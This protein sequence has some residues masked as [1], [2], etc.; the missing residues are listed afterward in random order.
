MLLDGFALQKQM[1]NGV[2]K[3]VHANP[4]VSTCLFFTIIL[5]SNNNERLKHREEDEHRS[6]PDPNI[7]RLQERH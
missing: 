5:E 7:N 4:A 6:E 1:F 3:N 2:G